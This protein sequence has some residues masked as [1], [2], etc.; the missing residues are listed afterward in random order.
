M[1]EEPVTTSELLEQ[2]REATRAAE[3]AERLAKLANESAERAEQSASAAREIATMAER[4]AEAAERA[5]EMARSA[6]ERAT[7]FA[8]GA[9]AAHVSDSDDAV[10][11]TK[12][13]EA[14]ARDRYHEA[15]AVARERL[16]A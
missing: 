15:E 12:A 3:L 14:A 2:W 9:S 4:S 7:A 13:E 11:A 5:A 8:D 16:G 1:L 10:T 6:A